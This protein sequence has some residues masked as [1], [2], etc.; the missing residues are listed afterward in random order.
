MSKKAEKVEVEQVATIVVTDPKDWDSKHV[1]PAALDRDPAKYNRTAW[2]LHIREF[3]GKPV[4][5]WVAEVTAKQPASI[6]AGSKTAYT[7][8]QWLTWFVKANVIEISLV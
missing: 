2:L 4:A 5:E 1:K 7:P 8:K 3:N 6:A